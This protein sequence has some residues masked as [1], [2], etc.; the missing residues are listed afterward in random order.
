MEEKELIQRS[1]E[2]DQEAFGLLVKKYKRK[3]YNLAFGLTQ[4]RETAD[5][6]AQ[7]A[8]IKAYFGLPQFKFKS[9]FSTWLYRITINLIKDYLRKKERMSKIWIQKMRE[10]PFIQDD[11]VKRKEEEKIKD[12]Q[13]K[14]V[15]RFI[16]A[17]PRKY[18]IILSLRDIHGFSYQE[19][20]K[21]LKIS[22]GTVDSRL[23]RA[24][25]MLRK[26]IEPFLRAKGGDHEMQK[27]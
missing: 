24:R 27:I 21:I 7:E 8:F 3:V 11:E 10:N 14:L 25:E 2:G 18:Q 9:E 13:R 22:P 23:H 6:L 1:K 26:N 19:I 4:D 16:R 15:H 17:L 5:D 12:E 20:S